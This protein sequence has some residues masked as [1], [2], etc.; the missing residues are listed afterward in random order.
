MCVDVCVCVRMSAV[1]VREY[2][3]AWVCMCVRACVRVNVC[4]RSIDVCAC[5][6]VPA[7]HNS[8]PFVLVGGVA[9][10]DLI[11]FLSAAN[12]TRRRFNPLVLD[13][14]QPRCDSA[15]FTSCASRVTSG[16]VTDQV[17]SISVVSIGHRRE[18]WFAQG[19]HVAF[20]VASQCRGRGIQ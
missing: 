7:P 14:H 15:G 5:V 18:R 11:G 2:V 4:A 3:L 10:A 6:C 8:S 9:A 13:P 1:R 16:C 20:G 17:E 19:R 12:E